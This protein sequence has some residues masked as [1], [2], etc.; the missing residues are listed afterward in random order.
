MYRRCRAAAGG[1]YFADYSAPS[2]GIFD[3]GKQRGDMSDPYPGPTVTP[4]P[5]PAY[6]PTPQLNGLLPAPAGIVSD[7]LTYGD[8][9][10]GPLLTALRDALVTED[11]QALASYLE[12]GGVVVTSSSG[13]GAAWV[14]PS[15]VEPTFAEL[16]SNG[17]EPVIQGFIWWGCLHVYTTGWVGQAELPEWPTEVP[18]MER[19]MLGE[20]SGPA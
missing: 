5:T 12:S 2:G 9:E 19:G 7:T 3:D 18:D 17:S 16:F 1:P 15:N 8:P 13:D 10:F 14:D 4:W 11:T 6:T 20:I